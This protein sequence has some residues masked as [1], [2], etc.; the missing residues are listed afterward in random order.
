MMKESSRNTRRGM[1]R[2]RYET[3]TLSKTRASASRAAW[4]SVSLAVTPSGIEGPL[5]A[6]R[7]QI[8]RH[9]QRRDGKSVE[10]H[11]P[12]GAGADHSVVSGDRQSPVGRGRLDAEADEAQ[13]RD[14]EDG[15]A[16]SHRGLDQ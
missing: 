12:P 2:T 9:H 8:D 5:D 15:I 6:V 11:G 16:Q 10:R 14:G 7:D 3:S 13:C 1:P 4:P